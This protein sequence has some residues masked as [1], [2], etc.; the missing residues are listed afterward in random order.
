V[1]VGGMRPDLAPVAGHTLRFDGLTNL[2]NLA[3]LKS[4]TDVGILALMVNNP[5]LSRVRDPALLRAA[6]RIQ[7]LFDGER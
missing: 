4:L 2:T 3:G 7:R 6:R 1:D 5:R